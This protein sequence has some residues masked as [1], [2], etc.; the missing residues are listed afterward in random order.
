MA[1]QQNARQRYTQG[2]G[3][4]ERDFDRNNY[5]RGRSP[6]WQGGSDWDSSEWNNP[7]DQY[8]SGSSGWNQGYGQARQGSSEWDQRHGY[9]RPGWNRGY[10]WD[11]PEWDRD[12]GRGSQ[13]YTMTGSGGGQRRYGQRS[14]AWDRN[15]GQYGRGSSER[16]RSFDRYG[17]F[18]R[19]MEWR[20]SGSAEW[21]RDYGRGSSDQDREYGSDRHGDY[22]M[23]GG[24]RYSQ[25]SSDR[26]RDYRQDRWSRSERSRE[27]RAEGYDYDWE[28]D[29]SQHFEDFGT[30]SGLQHRQAPDRSFSE[31]WSAPGPHYGRGPKGY[32]RS[33]ERIQEDLCERMTHHGYL[34][35]EDIEIEVNNGQVI[36]KGMVDSRQAKR[37]A[38]DM[39]ESVAGV[40]Q[41]MNQLQIKRPGEEKRWFTEETKQEP[42]A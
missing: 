2:E 10:G 37:L 38:E 25:R 19:D 29:Y 8:G 41:V 31:F 5:D 42:S 35:A 14:T 12:Y 1:D 36:L 39:A 22:N 3:R 9:S 40:S 24:R 7:Y 11:S 30:T 15:D 34:N 17:S 28:G 26:D 16:D 13:D 6:G 18:S 4:Y 32:Q 27:A 33:N 20:G 23:T 21:N